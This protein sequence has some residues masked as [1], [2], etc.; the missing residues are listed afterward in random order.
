MVAILGLQQGYSH[1][2]HIQSVRQL[3]SQNYSIS[4]AGTLYICM[5]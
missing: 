4:H 5:Y 1:G 3:Y 2:K